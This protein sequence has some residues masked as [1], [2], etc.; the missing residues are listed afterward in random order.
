LNL[1]DEVDLDKVLKEAAEAFVDDNKFLEYVREKSAHA[2]SRFLEKRPLG[3]VMGAPYVITC[4]GKNGQDLTL[5]IL[6]IEKEDLLCNVLG[7]GNVLSPEEIDGD[8]GGLRLPI[9]GNLSSDEDGNIEVSILDHVAE[10]I[11]NAQNHG[12]WKVGVGGVINAPPACIKST[13]LDGLP[14]SHV[15]QCAIELWENL[16][17]DDDE[18]VE[19]AIRDIS[20]QIKLQNEIDKQGNRGVVD[21][22]QGSWPEEASQIC[23]R[24]ERQLTI[25]QPPSFEVDVCNTF[26][27]D[28]RSSN[29]ARQFDPRKDPTIL[30]VSIKKLTCSLDDFNFRIE[31]LVQKTIFD[32]IFEGGGSLA[33]KNASIKLRIECRKERIQKLGEEVTVPVLQLQEHDV[34]LEEVKFKFK[35]TGVDWVLNKIVSN[36]S[37]KITQ[38]VID[39]LK[40]QIALSIN[41]AL[42]NLNKYIEVNPEIMLKILG[43]TIDD[44]EE[45][46]A[47]V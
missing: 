30:F 9:S 34:G 7:S 23:A 25:P 39:N 42:E 36:F 12:C 40:D 6:T 28:S 26:S 41:A 22:S 35:E 15:L 27:I 13:S 1:I 38:I 11:R 2:I 4:R 8:E 31:P 33:I 46:I 17:I 19:I 47:W 18:L 44:L 45:N 5:S 43:I 32:P 37:D 10:L 21:G 20:Y 16:D 14:L 24:H 3:D 29:S